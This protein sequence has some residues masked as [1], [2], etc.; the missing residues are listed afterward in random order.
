MGAPLIARELQISPDTYWLKKLVMSNPLPGYR[1][2]MVERPESSVPDARVPRIAAENQPAGGRYSTTA[3]RVQGVNTSEERVDFRA[4]NVQV[5][6]RTVILSDIH[7]PFE[8]TPLVQKVI[9]WLETQ[10]LE[11]LILNGDQLDFKSISR[12]KGARDYPLEDELARGNAFL[13]QITAAARARNPFCEIIWHDGNHEF[14]LQAY[15]ER[16]ADRLVGLKNRDGDAVVSIPA[17]LNLRERNIRYRTY[18]QV[19]RLPG[20]LFVEHGDRV[21]KNSA[22]TVLNVVRDKGASVAIGHVHRVGA[23]YKKDRSGLHRG[24]ETGCLCIT[25]PDYITE[26]SANWQQGFLVVDYTDETT[27]WAQ[28]VVVQAGRFMADGRV[29]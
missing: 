28:Q 22:G 21:S 19:T 12:Y 13:D 15:L 7:L 17:L 4:G 10:P 24:F 6:R 27:W 23:Y 11:R 25:D 5:A 2:P 20:G 9:S 1:Q 18:H 16:E 29:Y 14:R 3:A 8:D 26:D